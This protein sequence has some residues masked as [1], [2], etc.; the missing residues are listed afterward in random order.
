MF[1]VTSVAVSPR[2]IFLLLVVVLTGSVGAP[3]CTWAH[4]GTSSLLISTPAASRSS[5]STVPV[6]DV[7]WTSVRSRGTDAGLLFAGI[8]VALCL[9]GRRRRRLAVVGLP[10]LLILAG[11]EGAVHSVHHLGDP[12]AASHCRVASSAEHV[13]V[14]DV[15]VPANIGG[16]VIQA[17]RAPLSVQPS[18]ARTVWLSPDAGRAPPA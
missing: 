2:A 3:A 10:L 17:G 11:F 8:T 14:I 6:T 9:G 16:P 1:R 4:P 18:R 15:E 5:A 13:T 12:S 7:V